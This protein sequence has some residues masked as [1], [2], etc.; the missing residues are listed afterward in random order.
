MCCAVELNV[1]VACFHTHASLI[2]DVRC[3]TPL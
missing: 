3:D 2:S 1:A